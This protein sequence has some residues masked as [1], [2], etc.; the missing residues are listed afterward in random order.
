VDRWKAR[1]LGGTCRNR[2]CTPKK[3]L[4]AAGHAIDEIGRARAHKICVAEPHLDWAA[5][6]D[7][8]KRMISHIP[9]ALART[10]AD[11]GVDVIRGKAAFEGPNQIRVRDRTLKAEHIVIAT[12]SMYARAGTKVTILEVLPALLPASDADAVDRLV[13]ESRRIGVQILT[14]VKVRCV[15]RRDGHLRVSLDHGDKECTIQADRVVNGAGRIANVDGLNLEAARVRHCDGRMETDA[16]LRS[17]SNSAVHICGDVVSTSP[18]LSPIAT[19]EGR[20]VG[21]NIVE[22]PVEQPDYASIPVCVYTVPP[23][24]TVGLTEAK[25]RELGKSIRNHSNDMSDWLSARTYNES[26]AWTKVIVDEVTDRVLGAHLVGHAAEELINLFAMAMKFGITASQIRSMIYAF[27]SFS[28]DIK[29]M[30]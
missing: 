21:R 27:P 7:R 3:I 6:I 8:E 14:N 29:S 20:L 11:R 19:Y 4:V 17:V 12:G 2:G 5:L 25:V 28:A 16:Y 15:E 13:A 18:Q 10:M 24:A 1:D 22:G 9:G 23:L 26:T 30:L